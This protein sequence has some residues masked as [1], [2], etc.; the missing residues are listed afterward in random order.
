MVAVEWNS[1]SRYILKVEFWRWI[2]VGK[3]KEKG[4]IK[5]GL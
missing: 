4:G 3:G 2:Y 5:G 1:G